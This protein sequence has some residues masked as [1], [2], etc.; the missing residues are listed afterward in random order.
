MHEIGLLAEGLGREIL[1]PA[2]AVRVEMYVS[3]RR[4]CGAWRLKRP[5]LA[6]EQP[7][8]PIVYGIAEDRAGEGDFAGRERPHIHI[9]V[10]RGVA[11]CA[12]CSVRSAP[13]GQRKS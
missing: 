5:P 10:Y 9:P 3:R 2:A 13:L 12:T 11:P 8:A 4:H 6:A 1:R 7:H